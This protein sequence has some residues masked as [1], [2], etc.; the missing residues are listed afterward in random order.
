MEFSPFLSCGFYRK[1][2]PTPKTEWYKLRVSGRNGK[3]AG[4]AGEWF[5]QHGRHLRGEGPRI[6]LKGRKIWT[7]VF[8]RYSSN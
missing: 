8:S 4:A 3:P 1:K 6:A 7:D 2:V 5:A